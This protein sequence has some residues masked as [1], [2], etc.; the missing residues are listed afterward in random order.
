MPDLNSPPTN[1]FSATAAPNLPATTGAA[2]TSTGN[3]TPSQSNLSPIYGNYIQQLL[4]QAQGL[5]GLPYQPYTGNRYAALNPLL[6]NTMQAAAQ[7]GVPTQFSTGSNLASAAGIASLLNSNSPV[8]TAPLTAYQIGNQL[9]AS[10]NA[11]VESFMSPYIQ[12]V[13]DVNKAAANREFDTQQGARNA[14]AVRAG[15]FGGSRQAIAEEEARRNLN[16][17]LQKIQA[18]GMQSAYDTALNALN[19]QRGANIDVAKANQGSLLDTQKTAAQQ[20]LDAQRMGIDSRS[21]GISAALNAASTLGNLGSGQNAAM[22]GILGQNFDMGKY[23]QDYAQQANDFGYSQ[24]Q[25]SLNYPYK[26]LQ[27][28]S[29]MLQGLP[30]GVQNYQGATQGTSGLGS[31]LQ[32]GLSGLAL[33]QQLSKIFE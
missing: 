25:D 4:G 6:T 31:A 23:A 33:W 18:T 29:S 15:A 8:Q 17:D 24:W 1:T 28:M 27:F 12:N 30:L 19:Q 7:R 20:M 14:A 11:T 2:A 22:Q 16:Q 3:I 5:A 10:N 13:L 21:Q 26:N 9:D 32:G